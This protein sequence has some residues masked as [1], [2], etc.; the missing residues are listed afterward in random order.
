[1][2]FEHTFNNTIGGQEPRSR[3]RRHLM[4]NLCPIR[5]SFISLPP[6]S[7]PHRSLYVGEGVKEPSEELVVQERTLSLTLIMFLLVGVPKSLPQIFSPMP[8]SVD[9]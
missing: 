4:C 3:Y 2:T 8:S 9:S 5:Q 6:F 1:M 7:K